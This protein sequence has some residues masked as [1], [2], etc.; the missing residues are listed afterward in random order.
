MIYVGIDVS[1]KSFVVHAIDEKKKSLYRGEVEASRKGLVELMKALGKEKKL[2]VFEAGNQ[3]K[4]IS[5]WFRNRRD[6]Q[7][8]VVH[9]NE[10]KWIN[11]SSGKTD[12]VDAKKLAELARGDLLPRKVHLVSGK[13][14][15][16]RELISARH[17][18]QSKRVAL[19]N[20]VRGYML[21][22]G[23]RLPEKFFDRADWYEALEKKQ[24]GQTMMI[25]L[26]SFRKSIDSLKE[27]EAR[28]TEKIVAI[29]DDRL[30]LLESIPA[31]GKLSSRVLLSAIDEAQ[32][33]DNKKAVA[34][35]G[36]L[37]PTI[38]Q[39]GTVVHLGKINRD[40]RKEVRRV[41]L[42]CAHTL[43][44]MKSHGAMV[45][46]EFFQRIMARRGKKIAVVALAR[47]LLTIAYGV[48]KHGLYYDPEKLLPTKKNKPATKR[49]LLQVA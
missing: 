44:R 47:K 36:A 1:S 34:N 13:V 23:K 10:I 11:Q 29:E 12:K 41:L 7:L 14:Q 42:Q 35:Y 2:V 32:R 31:I 39:S 37:T 3:L 26:E 9:P 25:V 28:L 8:H 30:K 38:Y 22:E 5:R 4:W 46:K 24:L 40:G 17:T 15:S 45:L 19:I 33:F 16:L 20:S 43:A 48:L 21:Q 27:A 18:L 6:V 49:Y